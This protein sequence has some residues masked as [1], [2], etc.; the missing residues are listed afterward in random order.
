M[1]RMHWECITRILTGLSYCSRAR[2]TSW[3]PVADVLFRSHVTL[4]KEKHKT[5]LQYAIFT[6]PYQ[7][8]HILLIDIFDMFTSTA[9]C[10]L[11][12]VLQ[13]SASRNETYRQTVCS[14]TRHLQHRKLRHRYLSVVLICKALLSILAPLSSRPFPLRSTFF[15]QA[16]LPRAFTSTVPRERSREST[17]E[18]LCR[19]CQDRGATGKFVCARCNACDL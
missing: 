18:R 2:A 1:V 12:T 9:L 8:G 19:A 11:H 15:R 10:I 6:Q 17:R 3:K 4:L 5:T 13:W 7:F 14:I 16:L